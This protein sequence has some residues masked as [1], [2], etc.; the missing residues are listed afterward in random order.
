MKMKRDK[1]SHILFIQSGIQMHTSVHLRF[2]CKK[3]IPD[4][5][6]QGGMSPYQGMFYNIIHIPP[7]VSASQMRRYIQ[8]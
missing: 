7:S 2:T 5:C 6:C 8:N 1:L 3:E 4:S